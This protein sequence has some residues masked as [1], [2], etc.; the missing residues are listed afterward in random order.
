MLAVLG[1]FTIEQPEW[2]VESAAKQLDLAVS[3]AYRYFRSLASAGLIVAFSTGRYVLGPAIIQYDRQMRLHDPLIT[4]A[5][6]VMKRLAD[7]TPPQSVILLCRLYRNQVMCVHQEFADRPDF[8]VSY[9]RGRPMPLYRGAS[10]K[11]ILAHMSSRAVKAFHAE[12]AAEMAQ[13]GLGDSW[14]EV[15]RRLRELR[16]AG[17]TITQA[18]LDPGMTGIAAPLLTADGDVSGSISI[19]MPAKN[20]TPATL[21]RMTELLGEAAKDVRWAFSVL[22]TGHHGA[23]LPAQSSAAAQSRTTKRPIARRVSPKSRRS[24]NEQRKH[25]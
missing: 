25:R 8:A 1:L 22:A 11:I 7:A 5:Q 17:I 19:V 14:D 10:S 12:H 16:A 23:P 4:T 3:T 18:E 13:F 20:L 2:T 6:P 24:R 15:K 9:E 21:T